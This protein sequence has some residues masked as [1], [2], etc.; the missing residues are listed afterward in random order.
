MLK[1]DSG[2][3]E[4]MQKL[5]TE[6]IV[7]IVI[8]PIGTGGCPMSLPFLQRSDPIYRTGRPVQP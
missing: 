7:A 4:E 1:A 6:K 8:E 5:Q 3:I 2:K